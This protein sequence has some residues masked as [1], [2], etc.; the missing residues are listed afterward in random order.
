MVKIANFIDRMDVGG[1]ERVII[2][3]NDVFAK[4]GVEHFSMDTLCM[5][6]SPLSKTL[7]SHVDAKFLH[8]EHN[9]RWYPKNIYRLVLAC[10]SYD[11]LLV[12]MRSNY[13][14]LHL[15]WFFRILKTKLVLF[16]HYGQIDIDKSVPYKLNSI[17]KPRY[18]IGVSKSLVT[19]AH[20]ALSLKTENTLLLE[21]IVIKT[22]KKNNTALLDE[23]LNFVCVGNIKPVKNQ[24]FALKFIKEIGGSIT[25]YGQI[26]DKNYYKNLTDFI[27]TS[28]LSSKVFFI[29]DCIDIQAEHHK[30]D[31]GIHTAI[32][33]TG[34]LSI[35]EFA[36]CSLPFLCFNTGES[37]KA[38][39]AISRAFVCESF[40]MQEWLSKY[41]ELSKNANEYSS[42]LNTAFDEICNEEAYYN[43]LSIF[44]TQT[45][46]T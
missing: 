29:H 46:L 18:F 26:W 45:I 23:K 13:I 19:W 1:A 24:L 32:S 16:D 31:Y 6:K 34:P 43:K 37:A 7:E 21:N 9:K 2:T 22:A 44:I 17:F 5:Q 8:I 35:L 14:F 30:Y 3:L 36:A 15:L 28:G 4:Y 12:H 38:I 42:L 25:F 11:V 20:D 10:N 27:K 33:E 39:S 41:H 40:E